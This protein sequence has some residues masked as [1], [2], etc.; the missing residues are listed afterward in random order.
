MLQFIKDNP[1]LVGALTGSLAAYL[2]GLLVAYLRREKVWLG[3]TISSR[4]IVLK[5]HTKLSMKYGDR[6]IS[7][8][9][10]HAIV[11]RNI[12]NRPLKS[13]PVCIESAK[14]SI[15]EHEINP[16]DGAKFTPTLNESSLVV[17]CDLLNPGEAA[18]LGITVADSAD[19]KIKVI[20][21]AENLRLKELGQQLD[22]NELLDAVT[23]TIPLLRPIVDIRRLYMMVTRSK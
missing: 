6:E 11:L 16:P 20:A 14:G 18:T 23:E 8:L 19:G 5:G 2:L 4:N 10:S 21:R 3:Y 9:D 7:R 17:N 12:G 13:L 22:T 1:F 15:V